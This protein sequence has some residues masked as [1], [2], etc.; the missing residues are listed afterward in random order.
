MNKKNGPTDK[1]QPSAS[2]N[3]TPNNK[4][5]S[6]P[7]QRRRVL[8]FL[9]ASPKT[10]YQLRARG[11][12]HPAQRIRELIVSGYV[13]SSSMVTAYDS[14]GF[15]HRNVARYELLCEPRTVDGDAI[16]VDNAQA[17]LFATSQTEVA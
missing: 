15:E 17:D 8:E 13:I 4:D 2:Q 7:A 11:I 6:A 16:D 14:D 5:M 12:S 10:T 9:R 1:R 3:D